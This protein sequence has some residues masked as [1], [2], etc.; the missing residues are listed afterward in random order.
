V[1]LLRRALIALGLVLVVGVGAGWALSAPR[2]LGSDAVP[3]HRPDLA[4]GERVFWAGGCVSCHQ[5]PD[6]DDP[7]KL[8]GG[9][10][11]RTDLG[12]FRVPN[13]SPDPE[14]GIGR[15]S[16]EAF[17]NAMLRGVSPDGQHYYP[18]FPYTSY[19]RMT[20]TDT[21]D[22]FAYLKT[23]A[24]VRAEDAENELRFPFNIRR[25]I[26]LWKLLHLDGESFRPDPARDAVWNRGAYLV[27]G[28]AHCQE[29]HTPR[30]LTFG[31]NRSRA[32]AGAPNP[33]GEGFAPNITP[34]PD[35]I[36]NWSPAEI[37][38]VLTTGFTPEF[39]SVGGPMAEVVR[40]TARLP[41]ADR[42]AMAVYLR[43]LPPRPSTPRPAQ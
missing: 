43:S 18:A 26:G 38:E 41:P 7:L 3:A 37:V 34:S 9:R 21:L 15:W 40:H 25:G 6:Q 31:L 36:G 32:F 17:V 27:E 33:E 35:G 13:L 22:L 29:C 1:R 19:Q 11:L 23:L 20:V 8:G 39:D 2:R 4:N 42:E 28:P 10:A 16:E 24:P 30:T 12:T 14:T 5:T